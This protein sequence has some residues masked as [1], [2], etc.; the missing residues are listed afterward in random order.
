MS[1]I[2]FAFDLVVSISLLNLSIH[3]A[4]DLIVIIR[5]VASLLKKHFVSCVKD[6]IKCPVDQSAAICSFNSMAWCGVA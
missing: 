3:V 2:Y 1:S 6:L 5:L 4:G